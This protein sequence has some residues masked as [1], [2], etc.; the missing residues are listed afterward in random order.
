MNVLEQDLQEINAS[1]VRMLSLVKEQ[2]ELAKRALVEADSLASQHC[3]NLDDKVDALMENLEQRILTVIARR[4]PTARDLRFLGAIYRALADIERAGDY[5]V[6]VARAGEEL[7]QKPPLK[8]YTDMKHILDIL[9]VMIEKTIA[10]LAESSIEKAKEAHAM[11]KQ[12]DELYE[13]I[14]RELLTYMMEDSSAIST[15]TKLLAVARNLERFGDH[16]E[17]VNEHII[18]WLTNERFEGYP[19]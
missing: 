4:Q 11:D 3:I 12:I 6:H 16:L 18:F 13:Q 8:K 7:G 9:R 17:N 14:Q 15:A 1:T 10:A 5:A 19:D 2:S